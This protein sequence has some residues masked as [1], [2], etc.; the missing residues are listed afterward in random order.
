[1]YWKRERS[2]PSLWNVETFLNPATLS[3]A[4]VE[5]TTD[6]SKN[7]V[8][9]FLIIFSSSRRDRVKKLAIANVQISQ[10][11]VSFRKQKK[12]HC[13]KALYVAT[14]HYKIKKKEECFCFGTVLGQ[15]IRVLPLFFVGSLM[16]VWSLYLV[17]KTK[18]KEE[19]WIVVVPPRPTPPTHLPTSC[20]RG[21]F[22]TLVAHTWRRRHRPVH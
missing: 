3:L 6:E 1:M 15:R 19:S 17:L 5:N 4:E 12:N 7:F 2:H 13:A 21:S 9:C 16:G 22:K 20:I 18:S 11:F 10:H 14:K 8:F